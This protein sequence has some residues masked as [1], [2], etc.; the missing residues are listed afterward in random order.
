MAVINTIDGT[1][2][3]DVYAWH[4]G[5]G[6]QTG[7]L[8]AVLSGSQSEGQPPVAQLIVNGQ[9]VASAAVWSTVQSGATQV[10]SYTIPAGTAVTSVGIAYVNDLFKSDTDDRNL[11][12]HSLSLNG[13]SLQLNQGTYTPEAHPVQP[14]ER[15]MAWNGPIIF[16]GATVTD[17]M[18]AHTL[19][20]NLTIDLKEGV[21]TFV[22]EGR[23]PNYNLG[24][25][26][27]HMTVG[28]KS[29]AFGTDALFGTERVVFDDL[30]SYLGNAPL[31]V[32]QDGN[33]RTIDGGGGIDTV[34][35]IGSRSD[36]T[37][38]RTGGGNYVV[39]HNG[40]GD[41]DV[42]VNVERVSFSNGNYALDVNGN[43]GMA[44]RLYQAA[45]NRTPDV[46]GFGY[47][48]SA[49]DN[50]LTIWQVS[51]NFLH[52]PE[53]QSTYGNLSNEEFVRTLYR[54]V[55]HR[56]GEAGGVQFHT[57]NLNSGATV[58]FQTL[59]QFSESPENQAAVIGAIEGGALY[60]L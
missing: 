54:N 58:R 2:S 43:G 26:D 31:V 15:L 29:G 28:S 8:V 42:L 41:A 18:N 32:T 9:V 19:G 40:F 13:V 50:G 30:G 51:D 25:T 53:F 21:D 5:D 12:V 35:Y 22:Y 36:Y 45:F 47:Q 60:T 24:Y 39:T 33:N 44:Y 37:I 57:N 56:E 38:A 3:N 34:A 27:G 48:M 16:Q 59:V 17:A 10:L 4:R 49:L 7:K 23:F 11:F 1:A 20:S 52:S 14:G 6:F 46:G 55:L